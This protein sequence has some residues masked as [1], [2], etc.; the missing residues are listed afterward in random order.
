MLTKLV[1]I[2]QY[3]H[4]LNHFVVYLKLIE[5]FMSKKKKKE[6]SCQHRE[7][8]FKPWS[9]KIPHAKDQLS[10]CTTSTEPTQLQPLSH[11]FQA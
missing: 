10:L 6:S 8:G 5:C 11:N 9:K 1:I 2:S 3:I 4:M 7:H